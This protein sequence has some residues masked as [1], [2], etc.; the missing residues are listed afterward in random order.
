MVASGKTLWQRLSIVHPSLEEDTAEGQRLFR[1]YTHRGYL[2]KTTPGIAD[3]SRGTL[4]DFF[5]RLSL[6][7]SSSSPV[8]RRRDARWMSRSDFQFYQIRDAGSFIQAAW[9]LPFLRTDAIILLPVTRIQESYPLY[10]V[11]HSMLDPDL[12]DP[13]LEING[14]SLEDQFRLFLAAAHL[15]GL[16]VGYFLSPL[17]APE[18]AV[19]YR[20]PEFFLWQKYGRDS[21][22]QLSLQKEVSA[23]S[24]EEYL[25]T[26]EYNYSVLHRRVSDAALKARSPLQKDD[27]V[28]FNLENGDCREYFADIFLNL[29]S[30]YTL[31]FIFLSLPAGMSSEDA[32]QTVHL[33]QNPAKGSLKKYTGW[34]VDHPVLE[35]E[36]DFQ[37]ITNLF[38]CRRN[39]GLPLREDCFHNWFHTLGDLFEI[40]KGKLITYSRT[41]YLSPD[42][43]ELANVLRVY[44]MTRFSGVARYRRPLLI[45]D[46]FLK[47]PDFRTVQNRI[48]DVYTR[49]TDVFEKGNLM[50]VIAD[51][52]YAWWI[53][54]ERGRILISLITLDQG[55]DPETVPDIRIDYSEYVNDNKIFTVVEYDFTSV[56]G[57]LYLSADNSLLIENLKPGSFRLFSLQ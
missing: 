20:R 38:S 43:L 48:E 15:S 34:I 42:D 39:A 52:S 54:R 30:R 49:Y 41:V 29:Q 36:R 19:I 9:E 10:P 17:I 32:A 16:K 1:E 53:V 33:V 46:S 5:R 25:Q 28:C 55:T 57:S 35:Y 18:S 45:D 13:N 31:D 8:C 4:V 37:E 50:K 56:Q 44:Y 6:L 40:N 47:N 22:N 3:I 12:S 26:G 23:I 27:T 14:F 24:N 2:E 21:E 7:R 11:S 51:E